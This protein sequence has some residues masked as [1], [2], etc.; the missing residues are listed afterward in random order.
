MRSNIKRYVLFWAIKSNSRRPRNHNWIELNKIFCFQP[1]KSG[2][3]RNPAAACAMRWSWP[4]LSPTLLPS[5]GP[6]RRLARLPTSS[7]SL[8]RWLLPRRGARFVSTWNNF[9]QSFYG[10]YFWL[11]SLEASK[12]SEL[13]AKMGR[14]EE[15]AKKRDEL[16][17]DFISATKSALDQKMKVHTEKHEEFLGDL[18]NKVKEH[19]SCQIYDLD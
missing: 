16:T 3:R 5:R 10:V 7:P 17:Q 1:L 19:V 12:L 15:A 6:C 13:K 4:S 14:I 11:Q 9:D 8:R 18:I 2:A